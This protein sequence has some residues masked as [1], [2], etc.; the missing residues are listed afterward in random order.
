MTVR[1]Y[2]DAIRER[3]AGVEREYE[4][5]DT[6]WFMAGSFF[7]RYP[8]DQPSESFSLK[9]FKDAFAVVQSSVVHLQVCIW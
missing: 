1:G 4:E 2:Q 5:L 8:Y 3:A 7:R 6:V 9:V